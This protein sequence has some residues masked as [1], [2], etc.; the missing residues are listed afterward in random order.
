MI[1]T[2]SLLC[3]SQLLLRN[4]ENM[5][6]ATICMV[7]WMRMVPIS[8]CILPLRH[9]EAELFVKDW[10]ACLCQRRCV[11]GSGLQGFKA[12]TRPS[13]SLPAVCESDV[14]LSPH[15]YSA[16]PVLLPTMPVCILPWWSCINPWKLQAILQL[17][18]SF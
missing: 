6:L 10:K 7:V 5:I 17:N 8:S 12:H 18:A 13:V 1:Y 3:S 15:C 2:V 9:Q 14:K 11:T 16:M 4:P